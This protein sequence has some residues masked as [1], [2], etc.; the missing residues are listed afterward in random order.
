MSSLDEFLDPLNH[1]VWEVTVPKEQVT[2]PLG[3]GWEKSPVNVPT[4]GTIA[5]YRKGRY[6]VHETRNEWKVHLDNHDPKTQPYLHL[7]NDAPLLLMI[8]DTFITLVAGT[9]KK[10]G[11]TQEILDDQKKAWK[12][13]VLLGIAVMIAGTLIINS[14]LEF[15]SGMFTFLLPVAIVVIGGLTIYTSLKNRGDQDTDWEGILRGLAI[16]IAGIIAGFLPVDF[17]AVLV[18]AVITLWM[19]ASAFILLARVLKGR[20]AIPEGFYSRLIIALISL[21]LGILIFIE[22]EGILVLL[23][24]IIGV[25]VLLLGLMLLVNGLRLRQ[26]MAPA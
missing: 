14:P 25:I 18:L 15:F 16:M 1:G 11:N 26:M 19:F 8:G 5:S 10:K 9:R 7:I 17:W 12:Q 2:E 21:A 3:A 4:P 23:M 6:H 13:Q 22:P 20:K 24:A